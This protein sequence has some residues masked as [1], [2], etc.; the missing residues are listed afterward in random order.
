MKAACFA[1]L[2]NADG[3]ADASEFRSELRGFLRAHSL[4]ID[5][6]YF[7]NAGDL[8]E[9][10]A[11]V[12]EHL[13]QHEGVDV[14]VFACHGWPDGIQAGFKCEHVRGLAKE[15]KAVCAPSLTVALYCCST[16]ADQRADTDETSDPGPGGDGGFADRLRDE[17]GELGVKATVFAHSNAGH[18][19]RN[20][21]VRVFRPGESAGGHWLV[22][23]GSE[24][25]PAWRR[26][27]QGPGRFQFPF[28]SAAE[29]E[30]ELRG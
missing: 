20:P 23:P 25:W 17:L 11:Q 22:A 19:T 16:G 21:R 6:C 13:R 1:P 7:D 3:K 9:R 12:L 10:R 30:A 14:L 4:P 18:T 15:L 24:L 2:R 5:V 8:S 27:L 26:F 29:I 28:M